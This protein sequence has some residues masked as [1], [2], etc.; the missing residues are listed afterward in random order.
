MESLFQA[1]RAGSQIAPS[2]AVAKVFGRVDRLAR[3]NL[4]LKYVKRG[5]VS[6]LSHVP[7]VQFTIR[8]QCHGL[9][10]PSRSGHEHDTRTANTNKTKTKQA[11]CPV[12]HPEG[13]IGRT[14]AGGHDDLL[15]VQ[16]GGATEPASGPAEPAAA[17]GDGDGS[18]AAT[19]G[20]RW[21]RWLEVRAGGDGG[22][23]VGGGGR[24]GG[25]GGDGGSGRRRRGNY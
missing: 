18:S 16:R 17:R 7:Y 15:Q 21:R 23:Q 19:S 11:C 25:S 20:E 13:I 1:R 24:V 12:P 10:A 22:W 5:G 9:H 6:L 3:P 4:S 2:S 8:T 14:R